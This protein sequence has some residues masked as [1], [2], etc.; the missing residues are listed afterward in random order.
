[1]KWSGHWAKHPNSLCNV[2]WALPLD[3]NLSQFSTKCT[4][5]NA[6][7]RTSLGECSRFSWNCNDMSREKFGSLGLNVASCRALAQ[8]LNKPPPLPGLPQYSTLIFSARLTS[9]VG[10]SARLPDT[11]VEKMTFRY[12]P[13][14]FLAYWYMERTCFYCFGGECFAFHGRLPDNFVHNTLG[15]SFLPAASV[16]LR[17]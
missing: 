15:A 12:L 4:L 3:E 2:S 17:L 10:G 1:M 14:Q 13:C 8:V 5:R 16:S 6:G 7:L 11:R 9:G